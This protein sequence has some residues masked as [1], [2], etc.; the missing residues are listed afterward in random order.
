MPLPLDG[1]LTRS[2]PCTSTALQAI[3]ISNAICWETTMTQPKPDNCIYLEKVIVHIANLRANCWHYFASN[4]FFTLFISLLPH[5]VVRFLQGRHMHCH[6]EPSLSEFDIV[7]P[8]VFVWH[9]S[10][11]LTT[12]WTFILHHKHNASNQRCKTIRD[13][14]LGYF[15]CRGAIHRQHVTRFPHCPNSRTASLRDLRKLSRISS[16]Q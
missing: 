6:Q 9:L 14:D 16:M 5:L 2:V 8:L 15:L 4:M 13:F 1:L 12:A 7:W 10:A 11:Q 3:H